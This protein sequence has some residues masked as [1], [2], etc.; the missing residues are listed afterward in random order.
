MKLSIQQSYL[1][2][3]YLL[4]MF[5]WI[6]KDDCLGSLLGGF[7]PY[8]FV[9]GMSADPAA[10]DDWI[11]SVKKISD[12]ELLTSKEAFLCTVE[13]VR[14]HKDEFGFEL[15]W[16]IDGINAMSEDNEKWTASINKALQDTCSADDT[17]AE[18]ADL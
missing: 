18:S 4:D 11:N 7:N 5:Y 12:E 8:L 13:F 6:T 16:L 17:P 10:W 1:A 9:G 3:F 15:G 2:M 14:F